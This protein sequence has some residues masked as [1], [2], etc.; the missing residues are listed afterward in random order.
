[1]HNM[2]K[3]FNSTSITD[4][5]RT[6]VVK[7]SESAKK[8]K[9][10]EFTSLHLLLAIMQD[11]KG[12]IILKNAGGS[13]HKIAKE[14]KEE[15]TNIPR[16]SKKEPRVS[17]DIRE[18][19]DIAA[20]KTN[21]DI[22]IGHLVLALCEREATKHILK[23]VEPSKVIVAP[24]S[25]ENLS[26]Y[27]RDLTE[28]ARANKLDPIIGRDK[29]IR[30]AIQTLSRK[31]KNNPVIVGDP[32]VGKTSVAEAIA[33]RVATGDVPESLRGRSIIQLDLPSMVAG[34]RYR[35]QFEERL[36]S[37][38]DEI[39]Q[40][41]DEIILFIDEL[42][43]IMGT[44]GSENSAQDAA[45]ILKPALA[46]GDIRCIG[47][48][49]TEEYKKHIE[50]DKT[51]E[52]RFQ[53]IRIDEPSI[54]DSI[55]ILRG[56]RERFQTHHGLRIQDSA[57]VSAVKL[58][59]RY[60]QS[61]HLPDKA[62]DLV[63]EA[64]AQIKMEIESVPS[65]IDERERKIVLL[66][67]ERESLSEE[68]L[69]AIVN[70]IERTEGI[71]KEITDLE[72]EVLEMRERWNNERNL[73]E[74]VKNLSES[75]EESEKQAK[76]AEH[77]NDLALASK[78]V[79]GDIPLLKQ[80]REEALEKLKK[81]QEEGSFLRD[82][83][84][85]E[86]I[87]NIVSVWTGIPA[88]KMLQTK[89]QSELM[90]MEERLHNRVV[91]QHEA[92]VSVSD[93]IRQSRAGLS[94]PNSPV[95]TFLFLGPTGTG[96]TELAKALA[97]E[98]FDDESSIIRIDMSE[99]MEKSAVSR[100]VG[101]PP[102]YVGYDEGGQLTEAIRN[103]PYS[104]VLFDEIEKAHPDVWNLFL[105][106]FDEGRL[107]DSQGR[108]IDFTNTIVLMTSNIGSHLYYQDLDEET[109][110]AERQKILQAIFRPELLNRI[111]S[112]VYFHPLEQ[113]HMMNILDIQMISVQKRLKEKELTLELTQDAKEWLAENGYDPKFGARPLKRLI[114]SDILNPLSRHLLTNPPEPGATIRMGVVDNALKVLS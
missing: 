38:I 40:S 10:S 8:L 46:R 106:V 9:H 36:K 82:T 108:K 85:E 105:Q 103:K 58:S 57:L 25:T 23:D 21:S 41:K 95:G 43:S 69:D 1:M 18:T 7:S 75:I 26:K 53:P 102:G 47:A 107:T 37:V 65:S 104:I 30:R 5:T 80:E 89:T 83:V 14:L 42:H 70:N 79:Y 94:D 56:L 111:D 59:S 93:A 61:R 72:Q 92:I 87:A 71:S 110:N 16:V 22:N 12:K 68:H 109:L 24:E 66:K 62:I 48:T 34:A 45:S 35:G 97:L 20:N 32:G 86:D 50:K 54:D 98:L 114:S 96:K 112:I 74:L 67:M 11:D 63:D 99:Y 78:M 77:D 101:S 90:S 113:K 88:D 31:T 33:Y 15:L 3:K 28:L 44:G 27:S 49:S 2:G 13:L 6:L 4:L 60:I 17:D 51:L 39:S 100:L 73:I 19:L 55:A 52:R 81:L 84:C 29:E 91:G 64:C 76:T